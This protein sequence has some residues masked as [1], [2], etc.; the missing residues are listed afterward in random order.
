MYPGWPITPVQK[1][2]VVTPFYIVVIQVERETI[3]TAWRLHWELRESDQYFIIYCLFFVIRMLSLSFVSICIVIMH[4]FLCDLFTAFSYY[5]LI[6]VMFIYGL[7]YQSVRSRFVYSFAH[8]HIHFHVINSMPEFRP[9][10]RKCN[11][12]LM[13]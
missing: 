4:I 10:R 12:A 11:Y 5:V 6:S 8:T 13:R 9:F 2:S 3:M 7:G 1:K